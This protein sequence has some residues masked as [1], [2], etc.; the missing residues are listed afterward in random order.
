MKSFSRSFGELTYHFRRITKYHYKMFRVRGHKYLCMDV[1]MKVAKR[2]NIVVRS[3]AV[4]IDHVH[5][6]AT[7]PP[8]MSVSKAL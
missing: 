2:H 8:T 4:D 1:L 7:I 3:L 6:V 5:V